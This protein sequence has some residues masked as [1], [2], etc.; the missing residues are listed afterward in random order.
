MLKNIKHQ[1]PSAYIGRNGVAN[2]H[3][4]EL[5]RS[6]TGDG[7]N[8]TISPINR[9]GAT[10]SCWIEIPAEDIPKLIDALLAVTA[11]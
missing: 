4:I 2:M 5:F 11:D 8:V 9:N 1:R 3:G 7:E 6:K 10:N